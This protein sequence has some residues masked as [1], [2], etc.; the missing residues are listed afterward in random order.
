[1]A[2]RVDLMSVSIDRINLSSLNGIA[3]SYNKNI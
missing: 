1:M 3:I 2:F